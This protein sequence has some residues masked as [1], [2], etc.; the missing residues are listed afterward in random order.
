MIVY[1]RPYTLR[2]CSED[3]IYTFFFFVF[4]VCFLI[5]FN[6]IVKRI[7]REDFS[8][9]VVCYLYSVFL[10]F[11]IFL[12][13]EISGR[14]TELQ[15]YSKTS[16]SD[17]FLSNTFHTDVSE[18]KGNISMIFFRILLLFLFLASFRL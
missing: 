1:Y 3:S 14:I 18:S 13:L 6:I 16:Q 7:H 15:M 4:S 10:W 8:R 11:F 9:C 5:A 2:L 12:N 17:Q